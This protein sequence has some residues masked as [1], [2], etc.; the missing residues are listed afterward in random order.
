MCVTA[1]ADVDRAVA[2][3]HLP[4]VIL[5]TF[6]DM[7]RVPGSL[8][9][10]Q[11]AKADGA[12]VRILYSALDALQLAHRNPQRHVVFLGIGF[13]TTAPSIASVLLR[14]R[15]ESVHNLTVLCLHKLTPPATRAI[16][17][18]GDVPLSG[19]IGPGHVTT[20]IGSDAWAFLPRDYGIP[21]AIAGFEP[22]DVLRAIASLVDMVERGEP[23]V[24][25]AYPRGVSAKGNLVAR[26]LMDTVF[27][28]ESVEWRGL[29]TLPNSG[30]ALRPEFRDWDATSR[31]DVPRGASQE[32]IG[33]RC[34]DVLR[35]TIE[36]LECPLFGR[37]CS[38]ESPVGA[39]M[40]SGEG[41]CAA[42]LQYGG[43]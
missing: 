9:S 23:A 41:A 37:A 36:P 6:G 34:G 33:C 10:L 11:T 43:L 39:C 42:H 35:G 8:G 19:I 17:D 3:A 13:E 25:N 40:V 24:S 12:D 29:G 15:A 14:A 7:V 20:I 16:L 18:A 26:D 5:G 2:V 30:L 32:P 21:C 4:G 1:T 38:P 31:F 28:L 22:L 27:Q